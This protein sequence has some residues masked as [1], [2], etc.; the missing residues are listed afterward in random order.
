M[1]KILG[2]IPSVCTNTHTHT[3]TERERER[4]RDSFVHLLT[5]SFFACACVWDYE[6][7]SRS[8]QDTHPQL[9]QLGRAQTRIPQLHQQ[10]CYNKPKK[11]LRG[12]VLQRS[13]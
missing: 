3:H 2:L 5:H 7:E 13:A 9:L 8:E 10:I 12:D 11:V 1:Q 6:S 4:E